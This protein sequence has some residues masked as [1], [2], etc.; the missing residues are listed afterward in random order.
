VHNFSGQKPVNQ[1]NSLWRSVVAWNDDIDV[2]QESIAIAKG[3]NWDVDVAGFSD[4]LVVNGWIG[5]DDQSWFSVARLGVIGEGTW[6]ES[7]VDGRSTEEFGEFENG[8][9][10]E[11]FSRNEADIFW[12]FYGGDDSSGEADFFPHFDNVENVSSGGFFS[13]EDILSHLVV[14]VGVTKV[15]LGSEQFSG[16]AGVEFEAFDSVRHDLLG[17]FLGFFYFLLF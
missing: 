12:V 5:D 14:A 17:K 13:F 10:T 9:L 7:A 15:S 8:S 4:G 11:V 16:I 3:N 1:T 2:F 6:A